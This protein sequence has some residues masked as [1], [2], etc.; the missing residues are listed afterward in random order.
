MDTQNN[1]KQIDAQEISE[2]TVDFETLITEGTKIRI[3]I[4]FD[5]PTQN[6]IVKTNAI[7]RPISN[8]EW[9][10]ALRIGRN[11]L[12]EFAVLILQKGLLTSEGKEISKTLLSQIPTGV[13]DEL[14]KQ[15]QDLS[16]IKTNKQEQ[17]EL[18]KE[19]LGF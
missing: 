17:Y 8:V 3:P 18:T 2:K 4:T 10:N 7:I 6:G 14:V 9:N 5:F 12:A 19:L 15:I 16:G 1:E 13:A 11:N